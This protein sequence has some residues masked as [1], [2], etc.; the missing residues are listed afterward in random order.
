MLGRCK[1]SVHIIGGNYGVVPDGPSE[2]SVGVLAN[3]LTVEY[4]KKSG[5]KRIIWLP[6]GTKSNSKR[7]QDFIASLSNDPATRFGAELV[8]G[9]VDDL[10]AAIRAVLKQ[11]EV[12]EI[13]SPAPQPAAARK[14]IYL[15]CDELDR[16][17]TMPLRIALRKQGFDT[18]VPAFKGD[19]A[20]VRQSNFDMLAACDA[21]IVF[22]GVKEDS[23]KRSVD[24]EILKAAGA[25]SSKPPLEPFTY[26]AP[27]ETEDKKELV[28]LEEPKLINCLSGFSDA[29]L[30]EFIDTVV[31]KPKP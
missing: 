30:D 20:T 14:V 7:Q 15:I 21:A 31:G 16:E 5:L 18:R 29:A 6:G 17:A 1:L 19:A 25:R 22:Y 10:K 24:A 27:P 8:T 12:P 4:S 9:S 23:C 11:I 3:E 26:L 13:A 2:R 28:L